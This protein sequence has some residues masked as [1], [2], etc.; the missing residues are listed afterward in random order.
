MTGGVAEDPADPLSTHEAG[1]GILAEVG[2]TLHLRYVR[3]T[4]NV[5]R[6]GGGIALLGTYRTTISGC[7]VTGNTVQGIG[8]EDGEL[9][10]PTDEQDIGA[11][12]VL[13]CVTTVDRLFA[14]QTIVGGVQS[15]CRRI[16]ADPNVDVMGVVVFTARDSVLLGDGFT[17][18]ATTHL[19]VVLSREAGAPA[20]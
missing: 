18:Y 19:E 8:P 5:A 7:E 10:S 6:T 20:P 11:I 12:E 16:I 17:A 14:N 3:I 1:G 13:P 4:D 2:N 9:A 15:A